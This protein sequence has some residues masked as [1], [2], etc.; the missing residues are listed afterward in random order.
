MH[1][2]DAVYAKAY[3]YRHRYTHIDNRMAHHHHHHHHY[4][5]R[6]HTALLRSLRCCRTDDVF[7]CS[8]ANERDLEKDEH[9]RF[10]ESGKTGIVFLFSFY[11]TQHHS[12]MQQRVF[13][14]SIK[15]TA[16]MNR[17]LKAHKIRNKN[18]KEIEKK[19]TS[20]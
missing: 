13:S 3:H 6:T 15:S 10:H 19:R 14:E 11:F 4:S 2:H 5:I 12:S 1:E 16:I 9:Q 20:L 7:V 18:R 17:S 8:R